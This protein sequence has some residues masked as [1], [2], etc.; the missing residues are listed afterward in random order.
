MDE[1]TPAPPRRLRP[2]RAWLLILALLGCAWPG[3]MFAPAASAHATVA[4]SD[5]ADGSRL[6]TAPGSV[7]ITFDEPVGLDLGYLKVVNTEGVPVGAG[8]PTHPGG[9]GS[10]IAVALAPNLGAGTYIV[11]W[12]VISADSHPV[13]GTLRFLVGNGVLSTA[14]IAAAPVVVGSTSVAFTAARTASYLALVLLGGGWLLLTLWPAGRTYPGARRALIA[15]WIVSVVAAIAETLLQGPY[16]AGTGLGEVLQ[17]QLFADTVNSGY[18][19]LHLLRILL[20]TAL[21]VFLD[22]TLSGPV[23][24]ATRRGRVTGVVLFVAVIFTFSD[25]GHAGVARPVWL[26]LSGDILHLL[27]MSVWIGGLVMLTVALLPAAEPAELER[28]LPVFSRVAMV[29]VAILAVTGT[30]QAWRESGTVA[31]LTTTEYGLLVLL[32]AALFVALVLLGNLSRLFIQRRYLRPATVVTHSMSGTT[33]GSADE[34]DT[35]GRDLGV[36]IGTIE[37]AGVSVQTR[38]MRRSVLAEL[39]IAVVVLAASGLLVAQAPGRTA[40]AS[41]PAGPA[42]ASARLDAGRTV[43]VTVSPAHHGVVAVDIGLNG[44][45]SPQRLAVTASLPIEQL[46]PLPVPLHQR[47]PRQFHADGVLLPAAG[48]WIFTITVQSSEFDAITTTVDLPV[49]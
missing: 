5:P 11:S 20:L 38:R 16:A 48:T 4:S 33:A 6:A 49:S 21:G 3:L 22:A 45:A 12:R 41:Q 43:S 19:R 8:T 44:G 36:R 17:L 27:A 15:G 26:A 18:G 29:C 7:S 37:E 24:P 46:G 9:Q 13:Q 23:A 40:V 31:A 28:V 14:A 1:A 42:T 25:S 2:R 34:S 32:K 47:S 30:Y 10:V 39:M 35:A